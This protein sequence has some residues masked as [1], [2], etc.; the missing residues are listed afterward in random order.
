M[1]EEIPPT[2]PEL[3]PKQEPVNPRSK[4]ERFGTGNPFAKEHPSEFAN[5]P[6]RE[7][8]QRRNN[9]QAVF[10]KGHPF[11]KLGAEVTNMNKAKKR[12]AFQREIE[13]AVTMEDI[14]D[15]V[16]ALIVKAK[17]GDLASAQEIFNRTAGKVTEK[18]E[19]EGADGTG[20]TFTLKVREPEEGEE[21]IIDTTTGE[22]PT[23][24]PSPEPEGGANGVI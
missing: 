3:Q 21:L 1:N 2:K 19:I 15:I 9:G 12:A 8:M 23:S 17:K 7:G 11:A 24:L 5:V 20:W 6:A 10:A 14:R 16:A 18:V 22:E 4:K 13:N